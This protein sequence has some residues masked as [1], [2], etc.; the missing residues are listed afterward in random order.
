MPLKKLA[1]RQSSQRLEAIR[2][3]VKSMRGVKSWVHFIRT[4]YGM[5]LKQLGQRANMN[6]TYIH[7]IENSEKQ[8]RPTLT[9]LKKMAE[10]LDC[11][12]VYAFVPREKLEDK[13]RAQAL[14]KAEQIVRQSSLHME[15]EDQTVDTPEIRQ[16]IIDIADDLQFSKKIW[17]IK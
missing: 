1:L 12:L 2:P 17:E 8:G 13:L 15:L 5:T 7:Q 3:A 11:D 4:A 14:L 10:A 6:P 16:Q 9:T